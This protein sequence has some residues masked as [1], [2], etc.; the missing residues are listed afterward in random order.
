[1]HINRIKVLLST[2][3]RYHFKTEVIKT[4]STEEIL[5]AG[6]KDIFAQWKYSQVFH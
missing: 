5:I 2:N 4:N 6:K 1:M 3:S